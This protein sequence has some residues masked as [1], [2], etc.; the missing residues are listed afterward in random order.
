MIH[1]SWLSVGLEP[2]LLLLLKSNLYIHSARFCFSYL[3]A[4]L[5]PA[6][7]QTSPCVFSD[8]A[9]CLF[10]QMRPADQMAVGLS[11][12]SYSNRLPW[13]PNGQTSSSALLSL[14]QH[15][16][17][18]IH[19]GN[20]WHSHTSLLAEDRLVQTQM[21]AFFVLLWSDLQVFVRGTET[22]HVLQALP[23]CSRTSLRAAPIMGSVCDKDGWEPRGAHKTCSREGGM[24]EG[25]DGGREGGERR[26]SGQQALC[27]FRE[28]CSKH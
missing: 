20:L 18:H 12:P 5:W 1:Y 2:G 7:F 25:R 16:Q 15:T 13:V 6:S 24:E 11:C 14:R 22:I 10:S 19:C 3:A 9:C 28:D 26:T 4:K 21:I 23:I 17:P 8:Y 27:P